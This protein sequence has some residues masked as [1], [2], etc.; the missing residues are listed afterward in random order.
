MQPAEFSR[1]LDNCQTELGGDRYDHTVY[2]VAQHC[3]CQS[4]IQGRKLRGDGGRVPPEFVVGDGSAFRPP[5][6]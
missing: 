1:V 6:N 5:Q 4:L 3:L 2:E